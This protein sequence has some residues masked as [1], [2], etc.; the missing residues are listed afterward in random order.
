MFASLAAAFV[1][2]RVHVSA[3]AVLSPG[4]AAELDLSPVELGRIAGALP[5]L[6]ALAQPFNGVLLDRYGPSTVIAPLMLI[7]AAGATMFALGSR[8]EVLAVGYGLVGFGVSATLM[9]SLLAI[10]RAVPL[11]QFSTYT[12]LLLALGGLGHIITSSPLGYL[13]EAIGWRGA[14]LAIAGATLL[15]ALAV[16]IVVPGAPRTVR[17]EPFWRTFLEYRDVLRQPG[18]LPLC[19]LSFVSFSVVF[20]VR[21]L[22]AGPYLHDV[23]G[24]DAVWVGHVLFAMSVGMIVGMFGYGPLDRLAGSRKRVVL[25]AGSATLAVLLVLASQAGA[26]LGVAVTLL[27]LLGLVGTFDAVL[28]AHGRA[29]FP[30]H[31]AG[32]GITAINAAT[33]AGAGVVQL[34]TGWLVGSYGP[35]EPSAAV[36]SSVFL[37]LALLLGMG[38]VVYY[39]F[40]ED[41]PP[42]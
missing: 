42:E 39:R 24:L 26:S 34:T 31:M 4:I 10:S 29:L 38:L 7:A 18:V 15:V 22:W 33:F 6:L 1:L 27:V 20:A 16:W 28:L 21:A 9:G 17:R 40:A 11:R 2:T 19:A 30:A 36:Y 23:H 35:G 8:G 41:R 5:F 37:Y 14:M 3:L 12:G 32:R 25:A 13:A